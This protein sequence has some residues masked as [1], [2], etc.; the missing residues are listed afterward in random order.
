MLLGGVG[1]RRLIRLVAIVPVFLRMTSRTRCG[2]RFSP[3]NARIAARRRHQCLQD[4]PRPQYQSHTSG[5]GCVCSWGQHSTCSA[6]FAFNESVP[7]TDPKR[8]FAGCRL[9][10]AQ[11]RAA[12][13]GRPPR[14]AAG[15]H[16][17][18]SWCGCRP[19]ASHA[20]P[21]NKY[22]LRQKPS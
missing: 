7:C 4:Q 19:V 8:T 18:R 20:A 9:C 5:R 6:T 15:V 1:R 21:R 17:L 13:G 16:K 2:V 3:P 14:S 12:H 11:A 22:T 10:F